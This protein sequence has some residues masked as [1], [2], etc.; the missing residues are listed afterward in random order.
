MKSVSIKKQAYSDYHSNIDSNGKSKIKCWLCQIYFMT[1]RELLDHANKHKGENIFK[2]AL[3]LEGFNSK[4]LLDQHEKKHMGTTTVM[5]RLCNKM[6][7][8]KGSFVLHMSTHGERK[9]KWNGQIG[10]TL[11]FRDMLNIRP[12]KKIK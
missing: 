8:D 12:P 11:S 9:Q 4:M 3:C 6:F 1:Q 7:F 5:C 10:G 2:C